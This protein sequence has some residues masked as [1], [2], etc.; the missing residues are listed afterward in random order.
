MVSN[1]RL[2]GAA[3][4]VVSG[5]YSLW[6]ASIGSMGTGGWLM[7]V[8]GAVV[9]VHGALLLT[10]YADR[11]G[12]A[13]GPLMIGYATLMLL[14]QALLGSG[15]MDGMGSGMDGGMG[16]GMQGGMTGPTA[17]MGWDA[18]MVALALLMLLSGVIMS[19]NRDAD[20][21]M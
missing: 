9:L 21:G 11:L 6:S 3:I 16:G 4:G 20:A 19:R 7:A 14:N 17:S 12:D 2:Y 13:S 5:G 10:D 1:T 8:L 15:M 18:G